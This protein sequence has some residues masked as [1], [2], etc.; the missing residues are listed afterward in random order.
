VNRRYPQLIRRLGYAA[1]AFLVTDLLVAF[2]VFSVATLGIL[3]AFAVGWIALAQE[4]S[5][6]SMTF[7]TS[8]QLASAQALLLVVPVFMA[9]VV[10]LSIR[11]LRIPK[12]LW[13]VARG[14][15]PLPAAP[16]PAVTVVPPPGRLPGMSEQELWAAR[17]RPA[18]GETPY[19]SL[20]IGHSR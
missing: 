16:A 11:A 2:S 5:A 12:R 20:L 13:Q 1:L 19:V 7:G 18:R 4:Y 8:A 3:G 6:H 9:L 17:G 15:A 10:Y 14:R